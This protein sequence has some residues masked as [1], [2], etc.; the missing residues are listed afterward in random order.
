MQQVG[1]IALAAQSVKANYV[2][3]RDCC[4]SPVLANKPRTNGQKVTPILY[5]PLWIS[6]VPLRRERNRRQCIGLFRFGSEDFHR[7]QVSDS[8]FLRILD[9]G[10]RICASRFTFYVSPAPPHSAIA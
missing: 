1:P 7:A 4:V 9:F 10:L 8:D 2:T 6:P 5:P 3:V